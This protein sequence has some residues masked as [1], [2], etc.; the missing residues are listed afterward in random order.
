MSQSSVI[1]LYQSLQII[2][3]QIKYQQERLMELHYLKL[4]NQ[5]QMLLVLM[6]IQRI[7]LSLVLFLKN[8][9]KALLNVSLQSKI[10]LVWLL[11]FHAER[12]LLSALHL[13]LSS[14]ELLIKLELQELEAIT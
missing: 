6:E 5:I 11:D 2:A 1:Q 12:K 3:L 10:W 14:L 7:V 4:D 13:P 9:Q 8:T